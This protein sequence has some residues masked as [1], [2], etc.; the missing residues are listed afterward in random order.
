[1]KT[2]WENSRSVTTAFKFH[3]IRYTDEHMV[4]CKY[5][6]SFM[7]YVLRPEVQIKFKVDLICR[8]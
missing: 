4:K 8:S 3:D 6:Y 1:M 7:S 5:S 2:Y